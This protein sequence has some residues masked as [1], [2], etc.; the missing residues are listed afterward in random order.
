MLC[1]PR[2][3]RTTRHVRFVRGQ[4]LLRLAGRK[5]AQVLGRF[6]EAKSAT[7]F[8]GSYSTDASASTAMKADKACA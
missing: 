7:M 8:R 1:Y 2:W 3:R 5:V 4:Q 6:G